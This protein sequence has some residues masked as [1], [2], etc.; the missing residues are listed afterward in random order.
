MQPVITVKDIDQSLD[1]ILKN[2]CSVARFGDGEMD[3]IMGRS[4]PYQDYDPKL[5]QFLETIIGQ[6][7]SDKLLIC[8][9]DVFERTER[10]TPACQNFWKGHLAAFGTAYAR[11]CRAPWY[12][13]TFISRPYMDLQDKSVSAAY[14][15]QLKSIWAGRDILIVEGQTSRSGVGNDLFQEA[16]SIQRIICPSKNAFSRYEDILKAVQEQGKNRLVLLMLG[17]TAKVLAYQLSG[18]GYEAVDI[19]HIDSEYEWFQM[20]ADHKVKLSHKHTAEHNF[21]ENITFTEDAGYRSQIVLDI[22]ADPLPPSDTVIDLAFSVNNRYAQYLGATILSLLNH[23]SEQ[24][25][26]IHILYKQLDEVIIQDLNHLEETVANLELHFHLIEDQAFSAIPIRTEQFPLESFSRFL[27]PQLLPH[28]NRILYLDVDILVRGNLLAFFQQDLQGYPIGAV[29]ESD[30]YQYYQWYLDS[31]GFSAQDPY[32]SSG[33]LLM[34]LEALRKE[35]AS[36]ALIKAGLEKAADYKFPDQ[37][38]L[39]LYF[40]NRFK[41]LEAA[42]NYTDVRKMNRELADHQILIEHFNGDI[43]PWHALSKMPDYL[44]P[45]AQLY[46]HYQQKFAEMAQKPLVSLIVLMTADSQQLKTCLESIAEQSYRRLDVLLVQHQKQADKQALLET[47]LT[48]QRFSLH[49][50]NC[51]PD[52]LASKSLAL[53]KGDYVSFVK[54]SDWLDS[55]YIA[56]LLTSSQRTDADISLTSFTVY[57]QKEAVYR[58]FEEEFAESQLLNGPDMLATMYQMRWFETERQRDLRGKLY[59]RQLLSAAF[60][61]E[62][63]S[64]QILAIHL[65]LQ[66]Q[67][68]VVAPHKLYIRRIMEQP[69][70]ISGL[71]QEV[72]YLLYLH[73]CLVKANLM[74]T[75]YSDYLLE[76]LKAI[77]QQAFLLQ[78]SASSREL[79]RKLEELRRIYPT[80]PN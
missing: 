23:H 20:G 60:L 25:L 78:D 5:A 29:V 63:V 13:S 56:K 42:Y 18:L 70:T 27:L 74:T 53:A 73:D 24:F 39:N 40:K 28:I 19:G 46:H 51:Q 37:D 33:V 8:L 1:F 7:S 2:R 10:Y 65:Y 9:S 59:S 32:F 77:R 15:S 76:R 4:I 47:Y 66:A 80:Y 71:D 49:N 12:G 30:I 67:K 64:S 6:K 58:F 79:D 14:F 16:K 31:L 45:S 69:D 41:Q 61:Q 38:I 22:T 43:K 26:R 44:K 68:I 62:A 48:D 57:D 55:H 21:D 54:D 35:G 17:P 3:I 34:D 52:E 36:Q 75:D 50:L 11:L 72:N